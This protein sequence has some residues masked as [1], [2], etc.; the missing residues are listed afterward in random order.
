MGKIPRMDPSSP[1]AGAPSG[2]GPGAT[3]VA[4]GYLAAGES[5]GGAAE[6]LVGGAQAEAERL[7]TALE[8]KQ[9]IVNEVSAGR[10]AGD[11]E[12]TL[13]AASDQ[14]K[15]QFWDSPD[16]A[17]DKLLEAGRQMAD[18]QIAGAGNAAVG[19]ELA[20][21]TTARLDAAMRDI[22]GWAQ[23][24][25]TQKAKNDL[26]VIVNRA[27]FGAE[28][29]G[30][31]A[32][33]GGYI[34]TKVAELAPTFQKVLGAEAPEKIKEMRTGMA[35]AW[36]LSAGDRNPI[37]VLGALDEKSGP[38]VD[39][40]DTTQRDS[41][42]KETRASFEGLTRTRELDAIRKGASDNRALFDAFTTG[43][44]DLGGVFY[45][46]KRS[47]EEQT[48]AVKAGLA[49]DLRALKKLNVDPVG[50]TTEE[51]LSTLDERLKFVT[52][53]ETARR[54]QIG[55]DAEDDPTTQEGLLFAQDKA[56][57]AKK[58]KDLA[59]I[60]QQQTRLAVALSDKKISQGTFSTM[61]KDLSTAMDV[62]A[63]K[64]EDVWGP[65]TWRMWRAPRE[66]GNVELNRQFS[67][68]FKTLSKN[69]QQ[70]V[71]LAY[72]AQF[73]AAQEGGAGVSVKSARGMALRAL[74]LET[75]TH[76]PGVD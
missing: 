65:N 61:F 36:V 51:V 49:D 12:E 13:V 40:L 57:R 72:M 10:A 60:V 62:A 28:S 22:H 3:D 33:L 14:L 71:R 76:L 47:I 56:L 30:S 17:P 34:A 20:Q 38:L 50:L 1:S 41:L 21:R 69:D 73:N 52:A 5:F 39:Y 68:P 66:A 74:S 70:R 37:G 55:F 16:Q 27:T 9:A 15:K 63:S 54:R 4:G 19:L 29:K 23:S 8:A 64:D 7:R 59:A 2:S 35:R 46:Q 31:S 44:P 45:S 6:L 43:T 11:Y 53:L 26:S 24:R 25:Q 18:R 32:E 42:R 67:G 58:G 48:K 75:G